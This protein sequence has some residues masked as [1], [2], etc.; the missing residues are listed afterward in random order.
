[1]E[2]FCFVNS[3]KVRNDIS[4]WWWTVR[5]IPIWGKKS[6]EVTSILVSWWLKLSMLRQKIWL[7]NNRSEPSISSCLFGA[8][9]SFLHKNGANLFVD[10]KGSDPLVLGKRLSDSVFIVHSSCLNNWQLWI[11]KISIFIEFQRNQSLYK[12][13]RMDVEFAKLVCVL[14]LVRLITIGPRCLHK[15]INNNK[16]CQLNKLFFLM[17]TDWTGV[18]NWA[19]C[20]GDSHWA[21]TW[22]SVGIYS[23][24]E[25]KRLTVFPTIR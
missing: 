19:S 11:V 5:L 22:I 23:R 2:K 18:N 20:L 3:R 17:W 10:I 12:I 7:P 14:N 24:I 9:S 25:Q 16:K 8:N 1:M 6:L 15:L 4:I 21:F 13:T